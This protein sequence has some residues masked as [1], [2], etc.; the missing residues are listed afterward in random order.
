M[1]I[2]AEHYQRNSWGC[3]ESVSGEG[4]TLDQTAAIRAALPQLIKDFQIQT[5]LDIPCG[6]FNWMKLLDLPIQYL[7][8][9]VVEDIVAENKRRFGNHSRSFT[10][11]DLTGD[12]LPKVDLIF[13]RDCLFHFSFEHISSALGN[14]KRSGS[15]FLLTTTNTQLRQ[16]RDIVTGEFRRLNLQIPPFSLPAPLVIIDEQCPNPDKPD[17]CMGLWRISEL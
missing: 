13:C 14:M 11:L 9:D 5:M 2:F 3:S 10:R 12:T 8:A 7:G 15:R 1:T 17:K 6:D 4:S 16:N